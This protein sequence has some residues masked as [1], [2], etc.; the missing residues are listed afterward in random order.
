[1]PLRLPIPPPRRAPRQLPRVPRLSP[2]IVAAA[3]RA[4]AAV[5][6]PPAYPFLPPGQIG[7]PAQTWQD[8]IRSDPLYQQKA[9]DVSAAKA[10]AAAGRAAA[11]RAAL[12]RL[13]IVPDVNA[14]FASLGLPAQYQ[15]WLG[16]DID[17][18]TRKLTESNE[19]SFARQAAKQHAE[20]LTA[21]QDVLAAKGI[22]RSGQT[23]FE[24]GRESERY[25][26][27][28]NDAVQQ[29]LDFLGGQY[30]GYAT[31]ESG[32]TRELGTFGET[33]M[34]RLLGQGVT[35]AAAF[36][37]TYDPESGLYYKDGRYYD[38]QGNPVAPPERPPPEP[39]GRITPVQAAGVRPRRR[40]G[41]SRPRGR[42]Y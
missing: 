18:P 9:G 5:G 15:Q 27:S 20:N 26:G 35:P 28:L 41:S 39:R 13:G 34:E 7:V 25:Q 21:L 24:T 12:I 30:G 38:A 3:R 37:A 40:A 29:L 11:V 4:A 16:E 14:A 22:L 31:T 1:M 32:L 8:V 42:P 6:G 19:F 2:A 10:S 36:T 23:G 17:E 33:V